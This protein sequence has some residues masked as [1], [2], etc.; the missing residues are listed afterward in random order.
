MIGFLHYCLPLWQRFLI[1]RYGVLSFKHWYWWCV[2]VITQRITLP[3]SHVNFGT[4]SSRQL[5]AESY[6]FLAEE[7]QTYSSICY[8]AI[9]GEEAVF[10]EWQRRMWSLLNSVQKCDNATYANEIQQQWERLI[11]L[12][13]AKTFDFR[14]STIEVSSSG[15]DF[16]TSSCIS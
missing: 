13:N 6:K 14:L 9:F 16:N 1:P 8:K 5:P 2:L 11:C 10:V 4:S 12:H 3:A 7:V 15:I